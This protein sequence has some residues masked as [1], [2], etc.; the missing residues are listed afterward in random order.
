MSPRFFLCFSSPRKSSGKSSNFQSEAPNKS[1]I[2]LSQAN[3][4]K[5][6]HNFDS[7]NF[8]ANKIQIDFRYRWIFVISKDFFSIEIA[9]TFLFCFCLFVHSEGVW[10]KYFVFFFTISSFFRVSLNFPRFARNFKYWCIL[11]ICL[12]RLKKFF[13]AFPLEDTIYVGSGRGRGRRLEN[14]KQAEE[15]SGKS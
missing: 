9:S 5:T 4:I 7:V 11:W 2:C 15:F 12:W 13:L 14:K 10:S 3:Q 8:T 1:S 6:K